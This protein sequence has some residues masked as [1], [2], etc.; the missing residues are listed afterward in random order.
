MKI[1]QEMLKVR[2]QLLER[3]T[4]KR[5]LISD[6]LTNEE[7]INND[8]YKECYLINFLLVTLFTE[9]ISYETGELFLK[10]NNYNIDILFNNY[11]LEYNESSKN[12]SIKIKD[13]DR[14]LE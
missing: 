12:F 6:T 1:S 5:N 8:N 11:T 14:I 9:E 2:D 10:E 13:N 7:L 4:Q 3:F